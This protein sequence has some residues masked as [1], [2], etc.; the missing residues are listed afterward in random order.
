MD[1]IVFTEETRNNKLASVEPECMRN[2]QPVDQSQRPLTNEEVEEAKKQLV[3]NTFL[4]LEFPRTVRARVDPPLAQQNY[5]VFTF[6][7]SKSATPDKDGCFGVFKMRGTFPTPSEAEEHCERIIRTVDSYNEN[8]IGYVGREFPLTL[9]D[10]FCLSTKEV[11]IRTKMDKIAVDN[12]KSQREMDKK[13]MEELQE[14]RKELLADTSER[15]EVVMDDIEYYT[16]LRVKR[17]NLRMLQEECE[18]KIKECGKILKNTT[19]EINKLDDMF[20]NYK[21]EYEEK[22]KRAVESIGTENA[23]ANK[24]IQYMK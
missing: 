7:P 8:V 19:S 21:N 13:E 20:P 1:K 23:E 2:R 12:I 6:V 4:K 22:Y 16:Q 24:M 5:F 18:K 9:D 17:A 11:D 15:K 3:N 14:K 10:K